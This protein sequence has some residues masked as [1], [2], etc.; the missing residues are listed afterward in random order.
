[1]ADERVA[2]ILRE[3]NR[4]VDVALA[5][6]QRHEQDRKFW[7]GRYEGTKARAEAAEARVLR[8]AQGLR[9]IRDTTAAEVVENIATRA[10]A[11]AGVEDPPEPLQ[12]KGTDLE[13]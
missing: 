7:R 6:E 9:V 10:L 3:D 4:A 13:S 1:M 12:E 11:E 8:L 5:N 2:A